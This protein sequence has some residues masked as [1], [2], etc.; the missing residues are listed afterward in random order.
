M[1]R[2]FFPRVP[3]PGRAATSEPARLTGRLRSF[4]SCV[5]L[6]FLLIAACFGTLFLSCYGPVLF[7]DRQFGYRD[8]RSTIT[9]SISG[10]RTS[11]TQVDGRSGSA[12]KT[13]VCRF[14]ETRPR[15]CRSGKLIFAMMPYEW[16]AR[17]YIV[18]HTAL[19]FVAMLVLMRSWRISWIGST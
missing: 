16:G 17:V 11:G 8:A 1:D 10:C 5:V 7:G 2:L 4:P 12:K 15:Q 3:R 13:P 18:T 19:A 14:W 9:R 6:P